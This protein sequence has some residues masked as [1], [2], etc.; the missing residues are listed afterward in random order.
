MEI[1]RCVNKFSVFVSLSLNEVLCLCTSLCTTYVKC[2]RVCC[3]NKTCT[4]DLH[5]EYNTTNA[6]ITLRK[7][8]ANGREDP[9]LPLASRIVDA[10]GWRC[11]KLS[12]APGLV[13]MLWRCQL[14]VS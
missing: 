5:Y 13:M 11:K 6:F 12:R 1:L 2:V 8:H 4:P 9:P 14:L 10:A 7:C 3:T